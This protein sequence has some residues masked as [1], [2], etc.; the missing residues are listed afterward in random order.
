MKAEICFNP[1]SQKHH[2]NSCYFSFSSTP[3]DIIV[4]YA[5]QIDNMPQVMHKIWQYSLQGR[6]CVGFV[7]FEAAQAFDL[8]Y[9]VHSSAYNNQPILYFAVYDKPNALAQLYNV[10]YNTEQNKALKENALLSVY[11]KIAQG[12]IADLTLQQNSY[13]D[14]FEHIKAEIKAGNAYQIN[15]TH[16]LKHILKQNNINVYLNQD[17]F[18]TYYRYLLSKQSNAYC[19]YMNWHDLQHNIE[20]NILSFSPELFFDWQPNKNNQN[21]KIITQPM[22]GTAKRYL[23]NALLDAQIKHNLCTSHKEQA[24]NVMIVDLLRNDLAHIAQIGSIEVSNL[25][26]CLP[27]QTVWQMVSSI[28]ASTKKDTTL[29]DVFCALFPCGSVTGAPKTQATR[30][31]NY[32]EPQTRGVYCG[33]M[34]IIK[35]YGHC[36]FNVAI[37]TMH[38]YKTHNI[39]DEKH[40]QDYFINYGVGSGITID[41]QCADEQQELLNKLCFMQCNS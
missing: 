3:I 39:N 2:N 5:H 7:A 19:M 4:L 28:E 25:F 30:I 26:E 33:A 29:Y 9:S 16:M 17:F 20:H 27:L 40:M 21:G 24:E 23:D 41:A 11:Q 34:G 6:W 37:R 38:A 15:Y 31:I 8:S 18:Y 32:V 22:K 35:P 14:A 13:Q 36:I 10:E 1:I 12:L